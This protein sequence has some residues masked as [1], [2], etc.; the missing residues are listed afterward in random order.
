[1]LL[2]RAAFYIVT[3]T[4]VLLSACG[5]KNNSRA[6]KALR[7]PYLLRGPN[8]RRNAVYYDEYPGTV[9]APPKPNKYTCTKIPRVINTTIYL[10]MVIK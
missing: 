7:L 10:K 6:T 3:G 4:V 9:V 2:K 5:T 1:M 8:A